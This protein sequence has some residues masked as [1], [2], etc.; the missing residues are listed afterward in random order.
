MTIPSPLPGAP[1]AAVLREAAQWLAHLH[2]G[3]A[4]PADW[5]ACAAWR[6]ADAAHE[7]AWLRAERLAHKLGSV[8]PAVGLPVLA[9]PPQAAR[10]T[11][12]RSLVLAGTALPAAWMGYRYMPWQSWMADY[13]TAAGERR[14]VSL[15][16]GSRVQLDSASALDVQFDAARRQL[17]L[18]AGAIWITTAPGSAQ[19]ARP[20]VVQTAYGQLRALGTRFAVRALPATDSQ[21]A[22]VM[23]A[24]KQGAVEVT[25]GGTH[26]PA[27]VVAANQ[28]ATLSA[29]RV[30]PPAS[31]EPG[32]LA[33]VRGVLFADNMRLQ[34]L[35]TE[36][37]R[38]RPGI[39]YCAP[40]V[41]DL[42]IS[43]ALQLA[44]TDYVLT[45][46]T[47]S[48]PVRVVTR[49]RYWVALLPA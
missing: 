37:S 42:R 41:A 48:L 8:P 33:W 40:E 12:L 21:P 6:Q 46:L 30:S 44:D 35:C 11:V 15:P 20:F 5:A 28:Q 18:R 32:T 3:H 34:D 7:Q 31:L 9:R 4:G 17:V 39:L 19:Q 36:L 2:S 25:L 49:T 14:E 43:G 47:T 10:R 22:S 27:L 38:Y 26:T 1:S 13:H 24:V 23:V 16:D 29:T 45:M